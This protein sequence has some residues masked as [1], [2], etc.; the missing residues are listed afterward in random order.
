MITSASAKVYAVPALLALCFSALADGGGNSVQK[1]YAYSNSAGLVAASFVG[2][3]FEYKIELDASQ[4]F[5]SKQVKDEIIAGR[6]ARNFTIDRLDHRVMGFQVSATDVRIKVS[7]SKVDADRTRMDLDVEGRNVAIDSGYVHKKYGRVDVDSVYGIYSSKADKVTVHIPFETAFA[8][9]LRWCLLKVGRRPQAALGIVL[10]VVLFCLP[11][12][13]RRDYL[14]HYFSSKY[15][16]LV[17][18][19]LLRP[20]LR[21]LL[22][23]VAEHGRPVLH[24][25]VGPLPV[26]R[27]GVVVLPE[28]V[29][30]L[31]VRY[32]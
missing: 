7:P 13:G 5:P 6:Q 25:D 4:V 10:L 17:Q 3:L 16:R 20:C 14:R 2:G 29:E 27:G 21:L 11:E 28:N 26:E 18:L 19:L 30:E 1:A 8:L 22:G 23:A 12:R 9:L 24:A 31:A 32:H 15:A